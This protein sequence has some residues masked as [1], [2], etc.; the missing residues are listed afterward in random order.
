MHIVLRDESRRLIGRIDVNESLRPTRVPLGEA[1]SGGWRSTLRAPLAAIRNRSAAQQP[2]TD[3]RQPTTA[4]PREVFLHW[5]TAL[6]D[7]GQLRRCV[8]CGCT[9]LFIEKAFPMVTGAV[10]ALAFIGAAM[11]AVGLAEA[12]PV[13]VGMAIVLVLD[14]AILIFS[15]RRLVC[16]RCRSTYRDLPIAPY[17]R[18]WD[19][20]VAD[21]HPATAPTAAPP[22]GQAPVESSPTDEVFLPA[23][24]RTA[25][26]ATAAGADN[27]DYF[28]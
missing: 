22:P 9:D 20:S 8:A 1:Y 10:V 19:R 12:P 24:I 18:P 25:P 5:E 11:G 13:L 7:A 14:V 27:K 15:R 21:H 3:S 28:A 23:V 17:H 4:S 26:A 2:T 6:D 16:Y